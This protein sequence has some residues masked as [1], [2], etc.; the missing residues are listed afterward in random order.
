[1]FRVAIAKG[2]GSNPLIKPPVGRPVHAPVRAG[3]HFFRGVGRRPVTS[4]AITSIRGRAELARRLAKETRQPDAAAALVQIAT[5]LDRDA[6]RLETA[7][8]QEAR[9]PDRP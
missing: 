4:E 9:S 7:D 1:M 6:D 5:M 2:S 3:L 8:R